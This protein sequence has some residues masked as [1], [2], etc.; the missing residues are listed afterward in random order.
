MF[1]TVIGK[2]FL[3]IFATL[4]IF[5]IINGCGYKPAT[6]YAKQEISGNVFV[7][8]DVSVV[9]PKN[10]VIIKDSVDNFLM[11]KLDANLVDS[12]EIADVVLDLKLKSVSISGIQSNA[13]GYTELYKAVVN[14]SVA[15]QKR[16]ENKKSFVITGENNFAVENPDNNDTIS[17]AKR[18][19]AILEASNDA[20]KELL[21]K[22]AIRATEK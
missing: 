3:L 18:Y 4:F 15:Y 16:G 21:S 19:D 7:N 10:V 6:M 11:H 20:L 17:D 2:R 5:L 22:I 9:D 1:Y 8:L 12:K 13:K 14:I